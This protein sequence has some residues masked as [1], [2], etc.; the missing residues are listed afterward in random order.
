MDP[1][2]DFIYQKEGEQRTIL[3]TLHELITALPE[4]RSK[5]RY[6]IPFYDRQSWV[7]YLNPIGTKGVELCFIQGHALSN[8][9][10]LLQ[11]NGRK[12]VRGIFFERAGDI[13]QEVL[14][15][16]LQEALLLDE[17]MPY[18]G[19]RRHGV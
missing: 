19:P 1:C 15:E 4:I 7:C 3:I 2:L 11:A 12:Q 16:I 9:Q 8:V 14:L 13:D 17:D 18:R 5:L 10:G 6:R